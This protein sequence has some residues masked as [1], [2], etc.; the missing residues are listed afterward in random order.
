MPTALFA[1]P[2]YDIAT[3]YLNHWLDRGISIASQLGY[4]VVDLNG[5]GATRANLE[6]ALT[7]TTFD[8]IFLG[9]HGNPDLFTLQNGEEALRAC[10]NDQLLSGTTA[11]L[12][13][14]Y[15]GQT[16]GPSII[17]KTGR[18]Y[19]GWLSDFQFLTNTTYTVADDPLA[20]PFRDIILEVISRTLQ[21]QPLSQVWEGTIAKCEQLTA[22]LWNRPEPIWSQ[23]LQSIDH[24]KRGLIALGET[25]QYTVSPFTISPLI[26][27]T[28]AG[29]GAALIFWWI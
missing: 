6:S 13:S 2:N 29:I 22:A 5:N 18:G 16:L 10:V 23:V 9:G 21:G 8:F 17:A 19:F 1:R 20:A 7:Q 15:T 3:R 25:E 4:S 24:D 12:I 27:L 26:P 28:I 11:V 14:C